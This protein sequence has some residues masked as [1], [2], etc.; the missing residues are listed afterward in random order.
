MADLIENGA[1]GPRE[2][3][4]HDERIRV[5]HERIDT[6]EKVVE[7]L[8]Y[9]NTQYERP[10]ILRGLRANLDGERSHEW[11]CVSRTTESYDHVGKN[12]RVWIKKKDHSDQ[13]KIVLTYNCEKELAKISKTQKDIQKKIAEAIEAVK[14]GCQYTYDN[15]LVNYAQLNLLDE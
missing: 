10:E 2:T 12:V 5:L 9:H 3:Q 7:G 15:V 1:K 8:A 14:P 6:L 13:D 4:E 11:S